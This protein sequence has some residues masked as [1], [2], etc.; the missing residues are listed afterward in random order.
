MSS[1]AK[2]VCGFINWRESTRQLKILAI[3]KCYV[4]IK[5]W[6]ILME[7][8]MVFRVVLRPAYVNEDGQYATWLRTSTCSYTEYAAPHSL[9]VDDDLGNE[10]QVYSV[11]T[12]V[13]SC[14]F[15]AHTTIIRAGTEMIIFPS[16]CWFPAESLQYPVIPNI[17]ACHH[18]QVIKTWPCASNWPSLYPTSTCLPTMT[19]SMRQH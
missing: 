19:F 4:L 6:D 17:R 13:T 9:R 8:F 15:F 2:W 7:N 11:N 14:I 5:L 3:F 12:R 16:I 1:P 10:A 18:F